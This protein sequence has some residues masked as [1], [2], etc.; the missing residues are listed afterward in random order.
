MY[1]NVPF[2]QHGNRNS[3]PYSLI[4][5]II[6]YIYIGWLSMNLNGTFDIIAKWTIQFYWIF[7]YLYTHYVQDNQTG[8]FSSQLRLATCQTWLC[9]TPFSSK[10]PSGFWNMGKHWC[11]M[12]RTWDDTCPGWL[13]EG[14]QAQRHHRM[15]GF[16]ADVKV[17]PCCIFQFKP[18]T[19]IWKSAEPRELRP[20]L[21]PNWLRIP[22]SRWVKRNSGNT[23]DVCGSSQSLI[24]IWL[25]YVEFN[26]IGAKNLWKP[27]E[28]PTISIQA[29]GVAGEA[30][31]A[32][33][34]G[35]LPFD[36]V[37]LAWLPLG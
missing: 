1:T 26:L 37:A 36:W 16:F 14:K 7:I 8:G 28:S 15:C 5:I 11:A 27:I 2:G 29:A 6:I 23:V 19:E 4:I 13:G 25:N 22:H 32:T 30:R 17:T 21:I 20:M 35:L 18:A 34:Q 24:W 9:S 12:P 31:V 10:G 3:I 33:E